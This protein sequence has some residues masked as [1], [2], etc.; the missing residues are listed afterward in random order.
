MAH[1][2]QPS[3]K[4]CQNACDVPSIAGVFFLL[5]ILLATLSPQLVAQ[6]LPQSVASQ[7]TGLVNKPDSSQSIDLEQA[8]IRGFSPQVSAD[9]SV[10]QYSVQS[11]GSEIEVTLNSDVTRWMNATG[12]SPG[13]R[14]W[15]QSRQCQE[16]GKPGLAEHLAGVDICNMDVGTV[17]AH[18]Y[19]AEDE[20]SYDFLVMHRYLLQ[21]LKS[22]WPAFDEIAVD[23][24]TFPRDI[25]DFPEELRTQVSAWP[26]EV[27]RAAQTADMIPKLTYR[28][29]VERWPTEEDFA[30][31]LHCGTEP[32]ERG[33]QVDALYGALIHNALDISHLAETDPLR[34]YLFWQTHGWLDRVWNKY[35]M[36]IGKTPYDTKLQADLI[37]QCQV[38]YAW[39]QKA[40]ALTSFGQSTAVKQNIPLYRH[41]YLNPDYSKS[42]KILGEVI[43]VK[44]VSPGFTL[45]KVDVRLVG[46]TPV[47]ILM[48]PHFDVDDLRLGDRYVF[49]GQVVATNSLPD[50]AESVLKAP[51]LLRVNAVWSPK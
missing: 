36:A 9:S 8:C 26:D 19:C 45:Y 17:S 43:D 42:A 13:Y 30:R 27:L 2:L 21:S 35:R 39:V 18:R 11:T 34:F 32:G 10:G 37:R 31:W 50:D 3:T 47:W 29:V 33:M 49:V 38:H 40:N 20:G 1:P 5:S 46:V 4:L 15:L 48:P 14:L 22:L 24:K 44:K 16:A 41:G 7:G 6:S 23:W 25:E 28:E 12:W 51:A